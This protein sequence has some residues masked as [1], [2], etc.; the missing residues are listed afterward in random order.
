M[1]RTR[2]TGSAR[3][4]AGAGAPDDRA[5]A[6]RDPA[7]RRRHLPT[8]A[9]AATRG[10]RLVETEHLL[11]GILAGEEGVAVRVLA[12]VLATLERTPR[13][14]ARTGRGR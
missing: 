1:T 14:C 11:L 6:G 8:P 5:A 7:S 10:H 4:G 2:A 9:R 12:Q 13:P 3:P